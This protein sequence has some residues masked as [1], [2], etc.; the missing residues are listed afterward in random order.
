MLEKGKLKLIEVKQT[1]PRLHTVN[2]EWRGPH[3]RLLQ[4]RL[5]LNFPSY[6]GYEDWQEQLNT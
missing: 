6:P 1:W 4:A 3:H 5:S 2:N